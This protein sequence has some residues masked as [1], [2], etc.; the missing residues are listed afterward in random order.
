[1]LRSR[2]PGT[3]G[4]G[5]Q[6]VVRAHEPL[7]SALDEFCAK[8]LDRPTRA[9]ALRRF[10]TR[11]LMGKTGTRNRKTADVKPRRRRGSNDD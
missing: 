10:A 5:V 7:L 2:K 1:M 9:E 6:I 11:A 4:A 8:Q 3:V